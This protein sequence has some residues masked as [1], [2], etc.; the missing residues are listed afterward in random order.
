MKTLNYDEA[1]DNTTEIK[2]YFR[3]EITL[4]HGTRNDN[5]IEIWIALH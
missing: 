4:F 5:E 3:T 2:K 1:I